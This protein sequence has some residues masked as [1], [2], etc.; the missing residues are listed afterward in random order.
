MKAK[1]IDGK[2]IA[3]LTRDKVQLESA[4]FLKASGRQPGLAVILAGENPASQVYV[5][6]KIAGCAETG[7][8]SSAYYLPAEVTESELIELISVLNADQNIDGILVQLPLPSVIDERKILSLIEPKKDVDGFSAQN[9]GNLLLGNDTLAA[10]TPAGCIEL[11]RSTGIVIEG[12]HAVVVGRSNIVGKP[13]ALLL[14]QNNAT[15]TI[16]HSKTKNLSDITRQADILIAAVGIKEFITK[17]MIK[18]GAVVIDVGMNRFEGKLYG[19]VAFES[20]AEV[21]SF[22]TP[23]PG[24]V[25]PMTITMLLFNTVKAANSTLSAARRNA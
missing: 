21:S 6:N 16:C 20:C 2:E 23:V 22:I 17:D 9:A 4:K 7:I 24:G 8:K 14:L 15:V 19:D 11:I 10:C 3:R 1:L 5:R 18:P 12:K 13:A 25:G